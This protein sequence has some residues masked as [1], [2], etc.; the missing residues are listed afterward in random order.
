MDGNCER[1]L[2][3]SVVRFPS[4]RKGNQF[5]LPNSLNF[6]NV[7]I[8]NFQVHSVVDNIVSLELYKNDPN[9]P[10]VKTINQVMIEHGHAEMATESF[11][12]KVSFHRPNCYSYHM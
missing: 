6:I 4:S 11:L 3:K 8:D 12:S 7:E 5:Y 9:R 1:L 10:N 2:E